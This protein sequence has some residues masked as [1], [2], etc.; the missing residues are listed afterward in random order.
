MS[1]IYFLQ[2]FQ[3]LLTQ[4]DYSKTPYFVF[5]VAQYVYFYLCLGHYI[6]ISSCFLLSLQHKIIHA[7]CPDVQ[8][9]SDGGLPSF[10]TRQCFADKALAFRIISNNCNVFRNGPLLSDPELLKCETI[11]AFLW[12]SNFKNT[13][14]LFDDFCF[15]ND[16][17]KIYLIYQFFLICYDFMHFRDRKSK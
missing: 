17:L 2:K 5:F 9:T 10:Q 1:F 13:L 3:A 4:F 15:W 12:T 16:V 11:F 14:K 8:I 7:P 6:R